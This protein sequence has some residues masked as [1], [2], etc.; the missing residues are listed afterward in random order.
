VSLM[1]LYNIIKSI[2][3]NDKM[4]NCVEIIK[5]AERVRIYINSPIS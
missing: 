3:E 5:E 2:E 1:K 4:Y